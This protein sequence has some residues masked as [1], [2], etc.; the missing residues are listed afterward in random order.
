MLALAVY[1]N[2]LL[3]YEAWIYWALFLTP[4]IGMIGYIINARVGAVTYNIFHHKGVAITVF[5][6]GVLLQNTAVQLAGLVL[7]GHSS[8]DRMLGY[9]LKSNEGFR[10]THLG[11]IGKTGN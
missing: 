9:G 7:F 10:F 11:M 8:F 5:L 2:S 6:L 3:P 1:L 4:D